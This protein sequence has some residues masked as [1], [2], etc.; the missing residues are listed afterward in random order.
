MKRWVSAA[1]VLAMSV[2]TTARGQQP[3]PPAPE[4]VP[5]EVLVQY[6]PIVQ[7]GRRDAIA[8]ARRGR[9]VRRFDQLDI[10]HLQLD[11]SDSVAATV[12]A[13]RAMPEVAAAAPN[14]VRHAVQ[15]Q[16]PPP[17]DPKWLDGSLWGLVKIQAQSVWNTLNA[18]GDGSVVIMDIDT[19]LNYTHQDLAANVWTNPGEIAGNGVDDDHDGYVDDIHGIDTVNHDSDPND[20]NGHGSHTAGTIAA[21]GNNGLGVVGVNWNAKILPCKFLNAGGS[22]SD[23]G[24]A[25]C[26]NYAVTLKTL[27]GVNIRV[28]NNS[29]GGARN[30][31]DFSVLLN[32]FAAAGN[33]GIISFVAAGNGGLNIDIPG[34]EFDPASLSRVEPSI[35]AVAASDGADGRASFS[36][37]GPNSVALAAPG[38]GIWSTYSPG[39]T[40]GQLSGTSM[41]TPH[42]A[43]V[44]AL[45]S[46]MDPTLNVVQLKTLITGSVDVLPQWGGVVTTGGRLN[47]FAAASAVGGGPPT[48]VNVALASNGG[49]ASASSTNSAGYAPSG[50]INGNRSGSP[51]GNG[52]GWND[53]TP[54]SWPDWLEVDFNGSKTIG[55]I[56][57][58]SVQDNYQAPA[59]PTQQ[60]TFSLYGLTNFEAQYWT[61][62]AW[63]DVPGGAISGNN[64]V[65]RRVTFA[66]LSTPKIR[67]LVNAALNTWSRITEVEAWTATGP[68]NQPPSATLTAPADNSTY[69][70]P[71][72]IALT[73]TASDPDAGDTI[74]H[75]TF[76]ANGNQIGSSSTPVSG[77]YTF[78]WMNVTAGS[79]TLTAVATDNHSL[80]GSASNASHITVNPPAGRTNAALAA[81]GG[82]ASA[83]STFSGGYSASGANN[84]DRTGSSWGNGGGWNDGTANAW[85]DWLEVDFN[86]PK[87]INE[88]DVF[89][90]QDTYLTPVPPTLQ[91]TFG[92][93]GL[94]SFEV[95]YWT[96]STFQDVPGGVITGNNLVWRQVLFAALTT[97]KVRI[98]VNSALNTW[99]RI[100]EV[101]AWTTS[102]GGDQAPSATLTGPPN[103][104]VFSEPATITLTATASDP[105][106]GDSID[107]VTFLANGS[108]IG[109]SN[110]P[111]SGVYSF[112]WTNVAAG[113]YALTAV[114]TDNHLLSGNASNVDN[115]MV[116]GGVGRTNVARASN[117]ALAVASSTFSSGYAAGGAINGDR[118]GS[119]WGNGGGWNDGTPNSWPD[120]LEI[121]FNGAQ[122]I[123][124]VDV[125][126]LQDNYLAPS[127]P[128]PSMTFTLYGLRDF[129]V[130]YWT[131]TTWQDVPGGAIVNNNLVWRQIT[132]TALTTTKIRILVTNALD[133]W[134]RIT[135]V[136]AWTPGPAPELDDRR[137]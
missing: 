71:A 32:A 3:A 55:E 110:T 133:T 36:N 1:I 78:T 94:T 109:S 76:Y 70:E 61:G 4:Y 101:E 99:S 129:E 28:T 18:R 112:T 54:G 6:R 41:A 92:L 51:W 44:A 40:Y 27:H 111:V 114:A 46:S 130:Q 125:F 72:T 38:V 123:N 127:T 10:D 85:P 95:Q 2:L 103:N 49:V 131:G 14:Y 96:G 50:A 20:D 89:S 137:R 59:T 16:S 9:L 37:F 22:G 62:T 124:E 15:T 35:V 135:E 121:D 64:L 57:V 102:G 136:E 128:T 60:M 26:L 19:G 42:V 84:G 8:A 107:H 113:N 30:G 66:P 13:L 45:L 90:V 56:D 31:G 83:S 117:G 119:P 52:G 73:A 53:G 81:N 5:G 47:A 86:G 126:A 23:A 33:A 24:A 132:F 11:P 122:T 104:A 65:W 79:Y 75:V 17:N 21:A 39:N 108:P 97:T 69:T 80:S 87:T 68:V 106:A 58:F 48:S 93:Y 91:M 34:N 74:D 82:V 98:L 63:Q 88:V 118:T 7:R 134:T 100:T 115:V 29:W 43:G 116:N 77:T 12:A 67:I 120:W 25:E 105:D